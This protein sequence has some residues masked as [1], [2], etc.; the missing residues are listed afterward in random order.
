MLYVSA[1]LVKNQ[2]IGCQTVASIAHTRFHCRPQ[3]CS[4]WLSSKSYGSLPS[5]A[6]RLMVHFDGHVLQ[7]HADSLKR[8]GSCRKSVKSS[9][10]TRRWRRGSGRCVPDGGTRLGYRYREWE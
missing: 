1:S 10:M 3:K 6:A 7:G 8:S 4:K 9:Q 5:G 2:V